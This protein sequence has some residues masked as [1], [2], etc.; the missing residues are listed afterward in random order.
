MRRWTL[1]ALIVLLVLLAIVAVY[2]IQL[3]GRRERVPAPTSTREGASAASPSEVPAWLESWAD[4][5]D[6]GVGV[7]APARQTAFR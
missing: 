6:R 7:P 5:L 4:R 2:Q 1:I 3:A